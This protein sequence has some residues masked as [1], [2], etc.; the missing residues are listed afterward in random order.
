MGPIE[1]QREIAGHDVKVEVSMWSGRERV[2]IDG[3]EVSNTLS[4]RFT[5]LHQLVLDGRPFE[6]EVS[7]QNLWDGRLGVVFRLDGETVGV[8][9]WAL[10]SEASEESDEETNWLA[11]WRLPGWLSALFWL[12][13]LGLIVAD[14]VAT[15]TDQEALLGTVI[16]PAL[17]LLGALGV[18]LSLTTW[19]RGMTLP[20]GPN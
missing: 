18:A 12:P 7:I 4:W 16:P 15:F 17:L 20:T 6:V 10:S 11:D 5:T 14:M 8:T 19:I 9:R 3:E 1:I 2:L 13:Y